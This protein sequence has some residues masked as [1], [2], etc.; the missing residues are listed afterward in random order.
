MKTIN[1]TENQLKRAK[2]LFE[3]GRLNNSVT[4]GGG[5]LAGALGEIVVMDTWPDVTEYAGKY[6]YDLIIKGK[7]VD[8]KTKRSD[9]EP[10]PTHQQNIFAFNITQKCDY[11][12][13]VSVTY[14]Y[15]TAYIVG[16]KEKDAFFKEATFKKKGEV[17][18]YG[19]TRFEFKHDCYTMCAKDLDNYDT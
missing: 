14:D 10:Q 7:K 16:W 13:F 11:Y 9:Y 5:N 6:D 3:F 4:K 1:V 8:V 12:C 15:S 19:S 17:D 18:P 2:E